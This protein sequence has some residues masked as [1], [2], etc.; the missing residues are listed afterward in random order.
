MLDHDH[1]DVS[2]TLVRLGLLH[3]TQRTMKEV[4]SEFT[5]PNSLDFSK[6]MVPVRLAK[7]EGEKLV[8]RSQA[9]RLVARFE[10]F[11]T[12][13]LDFT[14]VTEIGQAFADEVFRVFTTSHPEISL[15]VINAATD[16][17]DMIARATAPR[18]RT[19]R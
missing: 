16:V 7:H 6:T 18:E 11:R 2:G 9:K 19:L 3:D 15:S 13:I 12:V 8:S 1:G 17:Q 5:E 14:G 4:Y 10:M